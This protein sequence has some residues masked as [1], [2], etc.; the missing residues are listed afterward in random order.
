MSATVI[1]DGET[2]RRSYPGN[3]GHYATSG[4]EF[5]RGLDLIGHAGR[6]TEEAGAAAVGARVPCDDDGPDFERKPDGLADP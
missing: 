2:Q 3:F 4:W 1:G 5:V 6:I